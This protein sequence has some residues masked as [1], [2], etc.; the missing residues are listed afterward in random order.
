[1]L[2]TVSET[3]LA[4]PL[5]FSRLYLRDT[6]VR[7]PNRLCKESLSEILDGKKVLVMEDSIS[8]GQSIRNVMDFV[9]L[10]GAERVFGT[11]LSYTTRIFSGPIN[12]PEI[13]IDSY[14]P[15]IIRLI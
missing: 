5:R 10:N 2:K 3:F 9:S 1:M 8:N 4:L 13:S 14:T 7:V 6:V 11:A 15:L 12:C